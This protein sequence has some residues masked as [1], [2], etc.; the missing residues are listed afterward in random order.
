MTTAFNEKTLI[1]YFYKELYPSI[2]AQLNYWGC[3]LDLWEEIVE[4]L[5][6]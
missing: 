2:Q 3:D 1:R 6:M 4:K 5:L